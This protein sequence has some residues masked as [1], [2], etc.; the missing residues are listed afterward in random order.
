[1]L[2]ITLQKTGDT[3]HIGD[4]VKVIYNGLRRG[5]PRIGIETRDDTVNVKKDRGYADAT[6]KGF[7]DRPPI[8]RPDLYMSPGSI[9]FTPP[10]QEGGQYTKLPSHMAP[11]RDLPAIYIFRWKSRSEVEAFLTA[12][13]VCAERHQNL[14]TDLIKKPDGWYTLFIDWNEAYCLEINDMTKGGKR[15]LFDLSS[16]AA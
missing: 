13:K 11:D 10:L 14:N 8:K 12:V 3:V 5:E 1:M 7:L 6:K 15:R 9:S 16:D 4:D 2:V